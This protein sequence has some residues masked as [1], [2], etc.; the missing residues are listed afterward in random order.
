[1]METQC[2]TGGF[3]PEKEVEEQPTVGDVEAILEEQAEDAATTTAAL[4]NVYRQPLQWPG[5]IFIGRFPRAQFRRS[6]SQL[7]LTIEGAADGSEGS[8]TINP[9]VKGLFSAKAIATQAH[10]RN[11]D[12]IVAAQ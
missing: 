2:A 10:P 7:R 3:L 9:F 11:E 4:P 5:H 1:M 12:T 6:Q 8:G